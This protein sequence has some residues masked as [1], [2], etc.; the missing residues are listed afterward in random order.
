MEE[1]IQAQYREEKNVQT[2]AR[3]NHEGWTSVNTKKEEAQ[4]SVTLHHSPRTYVFAKKISF[5][6]EFPTNDIQDT[7]GK[8]FVAKGELCD[9]FILL[10]LDKY[11][12][13]MFYLFR[14]NFWIKIC[15]N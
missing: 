10:L 11:V 7:K 14:K 5:K 6:N 1:M 8:H 9:W 13:H 4:S 12:K 2:H 15:L 3:A